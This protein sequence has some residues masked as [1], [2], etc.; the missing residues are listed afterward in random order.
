MLWAGTVL[1]VD[2]KGDRPRHVA[3]WTLSPEKPEDGSTGKFFPRSWLSIPVRWPS[4]RK[5][6]RAKCLFSVLLW[7]P[8]LCGARMRC[9]L[10]THTTGRPS[11]HNSYQKLRRNCISATSS[12][13]CR[14]FASHRNLFR[15]L[16]GTRTT[17]LFLR[18]AYLSLKI[19]ILIRT[20][21][22]GGIVSLFDGG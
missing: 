5:S 22:I 19:D 12:F 10:G 17:L 11:P 21:E 8:W 13:Q 9:W 7:R 6:S 14:P 16:A 1:H 20:E 4:G 18:N 15:P 3:K 2:G